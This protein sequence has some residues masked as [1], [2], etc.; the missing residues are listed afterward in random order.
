[1]KEDKDKIW[2]P[3]KKYGVGW[4]FPVTWQGWIVLLS[5]ILLIAMGGFTLTNPLYRIP[6]FIGYVLVLSGL[7][8]YLCFKKGEKL[9]FRWGKKIS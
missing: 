7:F 4:G 2:F 8:V 6:F 5:Y 3:A 1:M 9:D